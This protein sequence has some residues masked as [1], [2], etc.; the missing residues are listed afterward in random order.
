MP[1]GLNE[2]GASLLLAAIGSAITFFI[3]RARRA[4]TDRRLKREYPVAG[5]FY[6]RYEDS[7][8]QTRLWRKAIVDLHQRGRSV[9]GT[10]RN[11]DDGRSWQLDAAISTAGFISGTYLAGNPHDRGYGSLFL[12]IEGQ[13]ADMD[14]LWAGYDSVNRS[15]TGGQWLFKRCPPVTI[16]PATDEAAAEVVALLGEAL[17]DLY[18]D[19]EHV[20]ELIRDPKGACFVARDE[21][22]ELV[23]AATGSVL[24]PDD[25]KTKLPAGQD[26]L[27]KGALSSVRYHAKIGLLESIAVRPK[28]RGRGAGTGL[29]EAVTDWFAAVNATT[30]LTFGWKT[31][32]GCH[33]GGALASS[34][35]SEVVEVADFWTA[36]SIT[37]G[38]SCPEDGNP[39]HCGAV[40]FSRP[41]ETDRQPQRVAN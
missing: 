22:G 12:A 32:A 31:K 6:T 18:I 35:F 17:G 29:V 15:V 10:V 9:T 3:S 2:V 21:E 27:L 19:R 36:D 37:N 26:D 30:A 20:V 23:G 8:G 4:L 34:G 33:I 5:R 40:I 11:L 39:C 38:Y 7:E 1:Y 25:L 14:G 24:S 41:I 28:F 16:A 13:N